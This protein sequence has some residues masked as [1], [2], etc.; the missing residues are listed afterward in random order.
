MSAKWCGDA[1]EDDRPTMV[2]VDTTGNGG[3]RRARIQGLEGS[4]D[5]FA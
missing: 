1:D 5:F 3:R 4:H 2:L